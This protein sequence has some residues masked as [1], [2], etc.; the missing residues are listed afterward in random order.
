MT[1]SVSC[2]TW[3]SVL[4]LIRENPPDPGFEGTLVEYAGGGLV[5]VVD[6]KELRGRVVGVG[7]T[8]EICTDVLSAAEVC[9]VG[10]VCS[11]ATSVRGAKL[12]TFFGAAAGG[13]FEA[14][15]LGA[16]RVYTTGRQLEGK[17]LMGCTHTLGEKTAIPIHQVLAQKPSISE[18]VIALN[19]FHPVTFCK[20]QLVGTAGLEVIWNAGRRQHE[21]VCLLCSIDHE[22]ER[23]QAK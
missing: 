10:G 9:E 5:T 8:A 7:C 19:Q 3:L 18:F 4:G 2:R 14:T 6:L 11:L 22:Q 15:G 17:G 23:G 20:A 12:G 13:A 16:G 21:S 1:F